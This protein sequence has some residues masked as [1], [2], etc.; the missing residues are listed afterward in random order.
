MPYDR[1]PDF[2]T[3][4]GHTEHHNIKQWLLD[5]ATAEDAQTIK[6]AI[7]RKSHWYLQREL[8]RI[9]TAE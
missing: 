9:L 4:L 2:S 7:K 6:A 8:A 5:G 3:L 1:D